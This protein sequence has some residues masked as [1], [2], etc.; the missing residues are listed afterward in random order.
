MTRCGPAGCS[1]RC[2]QIRL[3]ML[4]PGATGALLILRCENI[5]AELSAHVVQHG[6]RLAFRVQQIAGLANMMQLIADL[7]LFILLGDGRQVQNRPLIGAPQQ[8]AGQIIQVEAL[9]DNV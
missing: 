6:L 8:L 1:Y 5:G 9:H 7:D 2:T 3:I 4:P